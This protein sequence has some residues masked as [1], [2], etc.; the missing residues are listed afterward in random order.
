MFRAK[1]QQ[2]H[3]IKG[4]STTVWR[5]A[6]QR[7]DPLHRPCELTHNFIAPLREPEIRSALARIKLKGQFHTAGQIH[8]GSH[9]AHFLL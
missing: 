7:G 6:L 5:T 3:V 1:A 2:R 8:T 4:E 9:T